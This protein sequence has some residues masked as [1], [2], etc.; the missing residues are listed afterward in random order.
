MPYY[1]NLK[2][3][4]L[5]FYH[6]IFIKKGCSLLFEF[7]FTGSRTDDGLV[8]LCTSSSVITDLGVDHWP[9]YVT[10]ITC[11]GTDTTC[12]NLHNNPHEVTPPEIMPG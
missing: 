7:F 6:F 2:F 5:Q 10:E 11:H 9:R 4:Y 8:R 1:L 3:F 12:L